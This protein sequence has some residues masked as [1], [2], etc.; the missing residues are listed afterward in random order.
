MGGGPVGEEGALG[1][2]GGEGAAT[3]WAESRHR[4]DGQTDG[5]R[6]LYLRSSVSRDGGGVVGEGGIS[7]HESPGKA[8][9]GAETAPKGGPRVP[10]QPSPGEERA[11]GQ[12]EVSSIPHHPCL[13]VAPAAPPTPPSSTQKLPP[14]LC[15]AFN[16]MP[17]LSLGPDTSPGK[18]HPA[19]PL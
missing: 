19:T 13:S 8:R 12:L 4:A 11:G 18:P 6:G 7:H 9:E 15:C 1:G 3:R 14:T 2:G 16:Y 17:S 5:Q 10:A